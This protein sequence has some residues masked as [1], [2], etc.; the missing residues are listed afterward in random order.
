MTAA[1]LNCGEVRDLLFQA[2]RHDAVE[3]AV[4]EMLFE[5]VVGGRYESSSRAELRILRG[6]P[7]GSQLWRGPSR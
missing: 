2:L 3:D 6:L 1:S 4:I 5:H 7:S